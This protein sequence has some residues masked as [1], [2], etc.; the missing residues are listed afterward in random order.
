MAHIHTEPNQHD[1]TVSAYIVL[2]DDNEWKCLVH[3]HRKIHKLMQIGGHIELDETPWQSIIHELRD[4]TGFMVDDVEVLQHVNDRLIEKEGI[5]HPTP[6]SASTYFVGNNHYHSDFA[7][8]FIAKQQPSH[9]PAEDESDDLRWVTL[10]ELRHLV[11]SSEALEDV[12]R[13]YAFLLKHL[14]SYARVPAEDYSLDK[15]TIQGV[16]Y[17]HGAPGASV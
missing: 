17:N 8:G 11:D 15:P 14:E 3:F 10:T 2:Y 16:T 4:E 6:F 12:Y 13:I 9:V 5:T 7:Y 1:I